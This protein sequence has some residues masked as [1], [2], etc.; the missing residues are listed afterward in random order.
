M[1]QPQ[2]AA[3]AI[4]AAIHP[5]GVWFIADINSAPTFEENLS[6]P[7]APMMYAMSVLSCMSSGLSEEGGAGLGTVGLPEPKMRELVEAAGFTRF[8]RLDIP[9]AVNAFYEAR[10]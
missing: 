8:R 7:V 2:E 4:G 5:D 1:T 9:H 10:V 3:A 6:N